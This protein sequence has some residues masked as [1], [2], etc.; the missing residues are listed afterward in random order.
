[1]HGHLFEV[2]EAWVLKD[3][4]IDAWHSAKKKAGCDVSDNAFITRQYYELNILLRLIEAAADLLECTTEQVLMDYGRFMIPHLFSSE[5]GALLRSQG[6]TLLQFL[7]NLNAMHAHFQKSFSDDAKYSPPVF[8]CEDSQEEEEY[9]IILHYYSHRGKIFVP[10]VVGMVEALASHHFKVPIIMQQTALQSEDRS[11]KTSW[12]IIARDK[13]LGWKL[14]QRALDEELV[15]ESPVNFVALS[16]MNFE[17]IKISKCPFSGRQLTEKLKKEMKACPNSAKASTTPVRNTK[18]RASVSFAEEKVVAKSEIAH[19]KYSDER[20]DFDGISMD[21][22]KEVFPFHVV[23]DH[24]FKIQQVG[25]NLPNVLEREAE[26]VLGMH[27]QDVFEITSHV[28]GMTWEWRSMNN[29]FDQHFF[30][31]PILS[32]T[33]DVPDSRREQEVHFK[34]A[35]L[36]LSKDK[37]MFSLCP[38]VKNLQHL[39]DMGLTLSDLSLVTSQRDAVFLAE[40]VAQEAIKTNSLDKLSKD[41]KSEQVSIVPHAPMH[42]EAVSL[43]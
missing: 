43:T 28:T 42:S 4:A 13:S 38:D 5:Y 23:V 31:S 10:M 27:I 20:G 9:S 15:P 11:G 14:S 30:M 2:F 39:N 6:L 17:D 18:R 21:L 33:S 26:K 24:D 37:V 1:M 12:R 16:P 36:T 19:P 35:M 40:Y 8:W 41:L 3:H 32:G 34:A 7:S 22:L 29:L 25:V